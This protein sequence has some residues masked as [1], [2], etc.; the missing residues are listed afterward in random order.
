MTTVLGLFAKPPVPGTVKTRLAAEI[1]NEA[2]ASLYQAFVADLVQS[3]TSSADIRILGF[4]GDEREVSETWAQTVAC[5]NFQ[6]WAQPA[7][8]L[9]QRMYAFF[10]HALTLGDRAVLIGTDSPNLPPEYIDRAF[11]LLLEH[12]VV[13]G[14]ASDGGYY[15]IGQ[16]SSARDIFRDTEW[17]STR[18]FE[19][20]ADHVRQFGA[21]LALLPVW[22]DVDTI[23][24]ARIL[25]AHLKATS[26]TAI[27]APRTR[28]Q[29]QTL[30]EGNPPVT[31]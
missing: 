8:D 20:T 3:H 4:C 10:Q 25:W 19:Q 30:F 31:P 6:A 28:Q 16:R 15:L 23:D 7:G 12:D 1:G 21:G 13:I 27:P 11:A 26:T 5:D 17:S 9:G 29:L 18:V 22:Y 2:A 24:D 14:P